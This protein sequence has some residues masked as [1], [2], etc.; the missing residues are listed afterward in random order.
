MGHTLRT[1]KALRLK[2]LQRIGEGYR[3]AGLKAL[4]PRSAVGVLLYT[5][6]LYQGLK[7]HLI[8]RGL[9]AR[10]AEKVALRVTLPI[11]LGLGMLAGGLVWI[12]RGRKRPTQATAD[13][14]FKKAGEMYAGSAI[15]RNVEKIEKT[16]STTEV[17]QA[18]TAIVEM[19]NTALQEAGTVL[20]NV[21]LAEILGTYQKAAVTV[22]LDVIKTGKISRE[23]DPESPI[24]KVLAEEQKAHDAESTP[25][26]QAES[27]AREVDE[28]EYE[29]WDVD[30]E[31]CR[32]IQIPPRRK[33]GNRFILLLTITELPNAAIHGNRKDKGMSGIYAHGFV[34]QIF[35]QSSGRML[36]KKQQPPGY[37]AENLV[38]W[39]GQGEEVEEVYSDR[40]ECYGF[41]LN[42]VNDMDDDMCYIESYEDDEEH[43]LVIKAPT[44]EDFK[45]IDARIRAIEEKHH[46]EAVLD[47]DTT[48]DADFEDNP[49]DDV[50]SGKKKELRHFL[51]DTELSRW[52]R[53]GNNIR[54]MTYFV[55]TYTMDEVL[56]IYW[57]QEAKDVERAWSEIGDI[58][59]VVPKIF[60]T[61]EREAGS[62]DDLSTN[63]PTPMN[64]AE[65]YMPLEDVESLEPKKKATRASTLATFYGEKPKPRQ[66]PTTQ[67]SLE[68]LG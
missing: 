44:F 36:I 5:N 2:N 68:D 48:D 11:L 32:Y 25:E 37:K 55:G 35:S 67:K 31:P 49:E 51:R 18:C 17:Q 33:Y 46:T 29:P 41:A 54:E 66:K 30:Q 16:L 7:V 24:M 15:S 43:Q 9:E 57:E 64:F 40:G 3:A 59:E 38:E 56:Q 62:F 23:I 10:K 58:G 28:D 60:K 4:R 53:Y 6:P 14:I 27:L 47:D 26:A 8:N 45:A 34:L 22:A 19:S 50:P 65:D 52:R 13:A 42:N 21:S 39:I 20:G 1:L 61:D 63:P 12:Q